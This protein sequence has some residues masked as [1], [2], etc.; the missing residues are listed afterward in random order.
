MSGRQAMWTVTA[1][2]VLGVASW[3]FPLFHIRPLGAHL[4]AKEDRTTEQAGKAVPRKLAEY[5]SGTLVNELWEKCDVDLAQAQKQLGQQVG[6]GGAWYF[7]V[8]GTGTIKAIA[9]TSAEVAIE[10]SSRHVRLEL[11]A[12]VDNTVR[13]SL[14]L[15]ASQFLN[16]QEFNAFAAEL[17]RQV[18][19]DVIKPNRELLQPGVSV[20]FVGCAKIARKSDLE[21]LRLIPIRLAVL[22]ND[23]P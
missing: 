14:G 1:I 9:S 22:R 4:Q 16:S 10:G 11:D 8:Q 2:V 3:F 5:T 20:S 21:P 18:E 19:E 15:K 6:L 23:S 13:D 7:C 17:N 12:V